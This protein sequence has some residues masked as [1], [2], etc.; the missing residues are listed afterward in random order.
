M[1]D[2]L[3]ANH[4]IIDEK[5]VSAEACETLLKRPISELIEEGRT[6][7]RAYLASLEAKLA[8]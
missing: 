5:P 8:R 1:A 4:D 3:D 6:E 2:R 7:L